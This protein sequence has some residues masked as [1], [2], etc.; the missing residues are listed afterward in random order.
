[1]ESQSGE[2]LARWA[3]HHRTGKDIDGLRLMYQDCALRWM[4]YWA[5]GP[6]D[7]P[8]FCAEQSRRASSAGQRRQFHRLRAGQG[9]SSAAGS[10]RSE[11]RQ[12]SNT[13]NVVERHM[14]QPIGNGVIRTRGK[15]GP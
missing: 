12:F 13:D 2:L 7:F 10:I 11:G 15:H 3:G 8:P 1:M 9:R 14:L 6:N 4:N 5:F